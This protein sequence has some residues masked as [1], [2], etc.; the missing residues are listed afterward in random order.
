M[1]PGLVVVAENLLDIS[2]FIWT[3]KNALDFNE[4][5]EKR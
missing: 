2:F 1:V 4:C 3:V 5:S